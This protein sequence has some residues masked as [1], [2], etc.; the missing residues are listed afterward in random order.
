MPEKQRDDKFAGWGPDPFTSQPAGDAAKNNVDV[1]HGIYA[2][3]VPMGGQK[4]KDIRNHLSQ[5]MNI[6]PKAVPVINGN[7]ASEDDTVN[8]GETLTFITKSGEK[9][10]TGTV[11]DIATNREKTF[12][13]RLSAL[14]AAFDDANATDRVVLLRSLLKKYDRV[15]EGGEAAD[16]YKELIEEMMMGPMAPATYISAKDE[17]TLFGKTTRAHV[18]MD[19]GKE[20][21]PV[22][23]KELKSN[24]LAPGQRVFCDN[25]GIAIIDAEQQQ[26]ARTGLEATFLRYLES[27][28]RVEAMFHGEKIVL[29]VSDKIRQQ[30][31]NGLLKR[32]DS[33]VISERSMFA[34]YAV[35]QENKS[36]MR[37][38]D[39]S[40]VPNMNIYK[41]VANP[42]W[43][44]PW[45]IKRTR[46]MMFREDLSKRFNMRLRSS[47]LM[48]GG[49]GT[50]KTFHIK[51]YLS[52]FHE[53]LKQRVGSESLSSRVIRVKLS[54]LLSMWLGESDKN[55]DALFDDIMTLGSAPVPC[56]DGKERLL[57]IVV[58][59]E[60]ADGIS[61]QRGGDVSSG[62]VYDRI[63]TTLLQRFDDPVDD[64]SKIPL[65]I[66]STTNKPQLIDAGMF[67]RLGGMIAT[68][69]RLQT[70]DELKALL[71]LKIKRTF[72]LSNSDGQRLKPS[73]FIQQVI[74]ADELNADLVKVQNGQASETKTY[75][76]FMTPAL[77]E[78]ALSTAI[79][80][81]VFDAEANH[82]EDVYLTPDTFLGCMIMQIDELAKSIGPQNVKDYCD[83]DLPHVTSVQPV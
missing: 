36:K 62:G 25:H 27:E 63:M 45:L 1:V 34:H 72:P 17:K 77:V 29:F 39:H 78:Q 43:C 31:D 10:A 11:V 3:T 42:H 13:E 9:G 16:V 67:R 53:M 64:L 80:R 83:C 18:I 15:A 19:D 8:V 28:D 33:L 59:M 79:D 48:V 47:L 55:V 76:D 41:E 5:T 6:D 22:F 7:D 46:I 20:M 2:Q 71:K 68:F 56:D 12:D 54:E 37:F 30:Y 32:G 58:I 57:P 14:Y 69:R 38:L 49:P 44:L 21:F 81:V 73:D 26:S 74:S 24:S 75:R 66:I 52:K 35:P 60:E 70:D 23:R 4:V 40:K 65:V 51:A 61:A 50:G 82:A